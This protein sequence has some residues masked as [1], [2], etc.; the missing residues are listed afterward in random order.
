MPANLTVLVV[1]GTGAQ[2]AAVVEGNQPLFTTRTWRMLTSSPELAKSPSYAIKILTRSATS[3]TATRL[4]NLPNVTLFEGSAHHEPDIHQAL[5]GVDIVYCNTNGFAIGEKAEIYWGIRFFELSREHN[6]KH[7]IWGSIQSAYETSGYQARF[8]TGHFDGKQKVANW[9]T[10]QAT[11]PMAWSILTSCMYVEM[12]NELLAPFPEKDESGEE[13]MVF[14][15][16]V[17][18]GAP[19]MIY[20]ADLGRYA[21]W[22]IENPERSNGMNLKIAT[23]HL[24]YEDLART[25]TEITGRRAIFRDVTLDEYFDSGLFP[26]PDEKVGHSAE[27]D[28]ETLQTYRQNFTG[29]WN[30]WKEDVVVRDM[31]LLD[32]I[33]PDRVKS[34]GDW[35]K[36]SGYTGERSSVLKDYRDATMPKPGN[37]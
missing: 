24:G 28:D 11:T 37:G 1:G 16:P 29:F 21:R 22:L 25:Y 36:L 12:L 4:S 6:V 19:P 23:E 35:M 9:I 17:G 30:T 20:L 34:I 18:S 7:F 33:M 14:K 13:V 26:T 5:E 31:K 3:S 2:G 15:A 10:T 27:K 8:R 32:E